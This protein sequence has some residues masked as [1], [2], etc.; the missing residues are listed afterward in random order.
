MKALAISLLVLGLAAPA[1]ADS[2]EAIV[3]A[4]LEPQLAAGL[5]IDTVHVPRSMAK[6]D[7]DPATVVVASARA[8]RAGRV[9]VRVTTRTG[10]A[11]YVPVTIVPVLDVAVA[12]RALVPGDTV[13][14]TDVELVVRPARRAA[15]ADLVIGARVTR[16]IARDAIIDE[17]DIA[18]PAPLGRGTAVTIEI[19]RGGVHVRGAGVLE[20]AARPG[21][22]ATARI[23][24]TR[25]VVHGVL[26]APATVLVG[27]PS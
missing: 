2:V 5:G 24:A 13:L 22:P 10:E 23:G 19:H 8:L 18:L 3:R 21:Q 27:G 9:S 26:V 6:A 14:E 25:Q 4:Q 17:R 20:L 11:V 7:L 16:A 1:R 15:A 12:R